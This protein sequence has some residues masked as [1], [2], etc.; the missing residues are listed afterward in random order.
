MKYLILAFLCSV[1]AS[2]AT[3]CDPQIV[4]RDKEVKVPYRVDGQPLSLPDK[5]QLV[6]VQR[7][8]PSYYE[9][10]AKAVD[11]NMNLLMNHIDKL[12]D[13]IKSHNDAIATDAPK[14]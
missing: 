10:F 8:D 5:P 14:K 2:C 13:I 3:T 11:L 4:Y 9:S 6:S 1:L 12:R 7:S